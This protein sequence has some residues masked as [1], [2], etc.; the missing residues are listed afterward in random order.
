MK[1]LITA[2][3]LAAF[4]GA[5]SADVIGSLEYG[6]ESEALEATAGVEFALDSRIT[7]S[8]VANA[9]GTTEVSD[10]EFT[11]VDL[12]AS[13]QLDDVTALYV[14]V[15]LDGDMEY[16]ETTVGVAFRF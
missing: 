13:W 11:G 3:F 1:S 8:A 15:E 2:A 14:D 4:A 5:A 10:F 16:T 12:G 9:A 6:V 7:V